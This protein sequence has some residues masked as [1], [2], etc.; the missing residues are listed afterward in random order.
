MSKEIKFD[1]EARNGLV[2]G[3]Q[4][5]AQAVGVT[6]GP[7]GRNVYIKTTFKRQVTKDGVTVAKHFELDDVSEQEGVQLVREVA[8]DTD[9]SAGDG[10]TT[11]TVLANAIV[12]EGM[13]NMAAGANPM[14]LKKGIDKGVKA[15]VNNL[16]EMAIEITDDQILK[17][18]ASI[19]ANNDTVIG[20]MIGEAFAKVGRDGVITVE[21]SHTADTKVEI[22]DGLRFDNGFLSP[23]F[24]TN[25]DK[26]HCELKDTSVVV[27]N[28]KLSTEKQIMPILQSTLGTGV[29][30]LLLIADDVEGE[31][32][33]CA[34]VNRLQNNVGICIVKA[35]GFSSNRSAY[36]EDIA[37]LTGGQLVA[38]NT[39]HTLENFSPDV[40]GHA[41]TIIT[42]MYNTT[43]V[44]GGGNTD[45]IQA[46]LSQLKSQ[47]ESE[48]DEYHSKKLSE[49]IAN[50]QNGIGVIYVGAVSDVEREEK[51][52]RVVDALSATK[53]A[54]EEGIVP[55]GGIALLNASNQI[56]KLSDIGIENQDQITGV[57]LLLQ[58]VT[59]PLKKIAENAGVSGDVVLG[60]INKSRKTNYGFNAKTNEYV[61]DM[62]EAGIID[63]KKVTRTAIE[64]A[65]SIAG[66]ILT[67]ECT[68]IH[69]PKE[70]EESHI[71][72]F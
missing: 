53:A 14:E 38:P 10:T 62:I 65:A 5:L 52:D 71:Q 35:P 48:T 40:V 4:K 67:T 32:L 19:S 28:G 8:T 66:M 31:A 45:N 37:I 6:L 68:M 18:I 1:N 59:A 27:Y 3:I 50:L 11:A 42:T 20:N 39:A 25:P 33:K 13:K 61:N 44:S 12:T 17:N 60:N 30:T 64:N 56:K 24:M 15:I 22:V 57:Q 54:L 72:H 29:G 69:K 21:Q 16:N 49:R 70:G 46:R 63:P 41:G 43:I 36:L 7:Q 9:N 34:V 47:R 26:Q 51:K 23:Y 58:A 2:S 55:G